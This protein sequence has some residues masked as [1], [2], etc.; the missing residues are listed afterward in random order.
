ML[1][2]PQISKYFSVSR[3]HSRHQLLSRLTITKPEEDQ[4]LEA[5]TR[6]ATV[7]TS[8]VAVVSLL[9]AAFYFLYNRTVRIYLQILSRLDLDNNNFEYLQTILFSFSFIH[10]LKSF[11]KLTQMRKHV[12]VSFLFF[13]VHKSP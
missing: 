3:V 12:T 10:G 13:F 2:L 8:C 6:V 5:V 4:S 9:E 11:R 7:S 1:I